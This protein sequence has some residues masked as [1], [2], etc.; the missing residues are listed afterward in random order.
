MKFLC[1]RTTLKLHVDAQKHVVAPT[2]SSTTTFALVSELRML[3]QRFPM[4]SG[5]SNHTGSSQPR[6]AGSTSG[7]LTPGVA[8]G[9]RSRSLSASVPHGASRAP[10][11]GTGNTIQPSGIIV[12]TPSEGSL[13]EPIM[14]GVRR[15]RSDS[16]D[17]YDMT[18]SLSPSQTKKLKLYTDEVAERTGCPREVLH[19]F[20]DAG[21]VFHMLIDL[22]ANSFIRI[23]E[24]E[25]AALVDLKEL[26]DSKDFRSALQSRLTACLLSPNLTAYVHDTHTNIMEFIKNHRNVFKIPVALIDDVE[27][28][29]QLS[30]IVSELLSSIRGNLKGKLVSSL[31]KCMSIMDTAKS[32]AHGIIEVDAAHWNRY[33]FLWRCLRIFLIGIGDY[34]SIPLKDLYSTSLLSSLHQDLRVKISKALN[35]DMDLGVSE[36]DEQHTDNADSNVDHSEEQDPE[37]DIGATDDHGDNIGEGEHTLENGEEGSGFRENR[38]EE[39]EEEEGEEKTGQE[40]SEDD[41]GGSGFSKRKNGKG[42]K[43]TSMKFWNFIDCSLQAIRQAAQQ[44]AGPNHNMSVRG[45]YENAVRNILVEYFQMDLAEFPGS[46]VVPKL[47]ATT[48]PQWQ[49]TIQNSLLWN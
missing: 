6:R 15:R 35:C 19:N 30:K 14:A 39:G 37:G 27:L 36:N 34:R 46:M 18:Q 38:E 28:L 44:E 9:P 26:I 13:D 48:S 42:P 11:S 16:I 24:Q 3:L 43:F 7:L 12:Q 2:Q 17:E 45:T 23:D 10:L 31:V 4:R 49:T 20:V 1:S 33:A 22:K 32:L 21:S 8:G 29:A 47:L 40:E 25:K 41:D 5:N